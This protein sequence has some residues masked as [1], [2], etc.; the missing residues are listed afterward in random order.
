MY[1]R[2]QRLITHALTLRPEWPIVHSLRAASIFRTT[3]LSR[4]DTNIDSCS[5]YQIN[6]LSQRSGEGRPT[7]R[8]R[9]EIA[10][11]VVGPTIILCFLAYTVYRWLWRRGKPNVE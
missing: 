8:K 4:H 11:V 2:P 10:T 1:A 5:M 9:L 7:S 3:N 6:A